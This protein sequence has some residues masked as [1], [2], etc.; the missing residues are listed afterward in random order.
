LG[1]SWD[2]EYCLLPEKKSY[3]QELVILNATTLVALIML[4]GRTKAP[5]ELPLQ[6]LKNLNLLTFSLSLKSDEKSSEMLCY[7][8]CV[9][10]LYYYVLCI[11]ASVV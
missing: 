4:C 10:F 6:Y 2:L 8:Y 1:T 3:F 9:V 11:A 5:P 7:M